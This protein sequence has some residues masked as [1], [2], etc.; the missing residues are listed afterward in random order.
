MVLVAVFALALFAGCTPDTSDTPNAGGTEQPSPSPDNRAA[1]RGTLARDFTAEDF[2]IK[3][4]QNFT[5][6]E[7]RDG[8]L[9]MYANEYDTVVIS[10]ERM[11]FS[12]IEEFGISA[13]VLELLSPAEYATGIGLTDEDGIVE[14]DGLVYYITSDVYGD[15]DYT[16]LASVYKGNE[17]FWVVEFVV[18]VEVFDDMKADVIKWAKSVKITET[19]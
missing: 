7:S 9:A 14:E 5:E 4:T 8:F 16:N 11:T 18:D 19:E 17:A 1:I 12:L 3:L 10:V 13:D 6:I 15:K 2:S